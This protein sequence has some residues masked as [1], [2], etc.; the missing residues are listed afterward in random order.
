MFLRPDT[1]TQLSHFNTA[2]GN[3]LRINKGTSQEAIQKERNAVLQSQREKAQKLVG[4][5]DNNTTENEGEIETVESDKPKMNNSELL[6]PTIIIIP[7][8]IV[9]ITIFTLSISVVAKVLLILFLIVSLIT[10][11]LEY[12]K[13]NITDPLS[14]FS[15]KIT[16][17]FQSK[18]DRKIMFAD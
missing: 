11:I 9:I 10:Y 17:N 13:C 14:K 18:N 3:S 8:V 16:Q 1:L 4:K 7:I 15:Q 6:Y 2:I 12:K 5:G